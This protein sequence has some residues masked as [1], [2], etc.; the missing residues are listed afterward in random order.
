MG[1]VG[2]AAARGTHRITG[3]SGFRQTDYRGEWRIFQG[4]WPRE[5]RL[6]PV[7]FTGCMRRAHFPWRM[8]MGGGDVA[9]GMSAFRTSLGP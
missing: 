5:E 2:G 6:S 8:V 1:F 9:R 7:G 4:E 3:W